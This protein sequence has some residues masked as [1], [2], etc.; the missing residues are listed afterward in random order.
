MG[1]DLAGPDHLQARRDRRGAPHRGGGAGGSEPAD[2]RSPPRRRSRVPV[3]P[4]PDGAPSKRHR[5]RRVVHDGGQRA[6]EVQQQRRSPGRTAQSLEESG[7]I[8]SHPRRPYRPGPGP[9]GGAPCRATVGAM[10]RALPVGTP[11]RDHHPRR[12]PAGHGAHRRRPADRRSCH[13]PVCHHGHDHPRTRWGRTGDHEDRHHAHRRSEGGGGERG[14]GARPTCGC[15]ATVVRCRRRGWCSTPPVPSATWSS[16]RGWTRGH[17]GSR[18]SARCSHQRWLPP[19]HGSSRPAP[20]GRSRSGRPSGAGRLVRLGVEGGSEVAIVRTSVA[21][22]VD[23]DVSL[24]H[25]R[26]QP[27]GHAA[28]RRLRRLR[29]RRRPGAALLG[30]VDR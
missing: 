26:G 9:A 14:R 1:E 23:E 30:P 21:Q 16:W 8:M 22:P 10:Q 17:S 4:A 25:E 19:S 6:V 18:S 2:L 5:Q 7:T 29:P 13:L 15:D 28:I 27:V 11:G 20:G 24:G 3:R 12:L